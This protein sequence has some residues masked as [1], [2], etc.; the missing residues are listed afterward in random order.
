MGKKSIVSI[1]CEIPGGYSEFVSF[2]SLA[3]LLDWDIILFNPTITEFTF[4]Y[5]NYKGKPLLDDDSSFRLKEASD[6]WR[7]ELSEAYRAGKTIIIFLPELTEVYI[8]T[9]DRNYSGTGRNRQTTTVVTNYDNYKM[10]PVKVDVVTT[11]GNKMRLTKSGQFLGDYWREFSAHSSYKVL[12]GAGAGEPLV[13]TS[14]GEKTVGSILNNAESGGALLFLP[15][16]AMGSEEFY[17]EK[18]VPREGGE[19]EDDTVTEMEWTEA[20]IKFGSILVNCIVE[21]DRSLRAASEV[22]PAPDWINSG[23]FELSKES[24]CRQGLLKVEAQLEELEQEKDSMKGR[25]ATE[26][27]PKRLLFETGKPLEGAIINA[28]ELIGFHAS[29]YHDMKSEFDA[30]FESTEGRFLGEAEGKDNKSINITKL[31]QLEMNILEDYERDEVKEMAKGV[32]FGNAHRLTPPDERGTFFTDKCMSAAK[33]SGVALVRTTDLFPIVQ[34]LSTTEDVGYAQ[35]C[36]IAILESLGEVVEFPKPP[37]EVTVEK[38]VSEAE[39]T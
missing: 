12:I 36:R 25:L 21:I 4:S 27:R 37:S 3:S 23:G 32:L 6:H 26:G 10:I 28:L 22:T 29:N 14:S 16:L 35:N 13:V 24:E 2:V 34:Y 39:S 1:D 19:G 33:R 17:E 31:R 5:E 20:G 11:K 8:D 15:H 30:V 9:G 38:K 18:E 7:R